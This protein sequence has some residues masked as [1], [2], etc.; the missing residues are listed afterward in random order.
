ML[1][2][3]FFCVIESFGFFRGYW[4]SLSMLDPLADGLFA[5]MFNHD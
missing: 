2:A 5:L 3:I 1:Y 4:S